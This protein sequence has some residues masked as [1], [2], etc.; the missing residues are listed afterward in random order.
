MNM[1]G[2]ILISL[3]VNLPQAQLPNIS[4]LTPPPLQPIPFS[5]K[6]HLGMGVLDCKD[7]HRMPEPGYFASLPDTGKCMLCHEKILSKSP[8]I[9]KLA[10]AHRKGV[11]IEWKPVYRIPDYVYFSH[12]EHLAQENTTC[13]ACHGLVRK[14]DKMQKVKDISMPACMGCHRAPMASVACDY[15]HEMF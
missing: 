9:Q 4:S 10:V 12:K 11:A 15:C 13:Q 8:S 5:H 2:L 14:M 1:Q 7:C 6:Q 3:L